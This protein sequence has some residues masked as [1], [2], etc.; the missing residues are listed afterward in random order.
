MTGDER[1]LRAQLAG[2]G[3]ALVALSGGVDSALVLAVAAAEL[4]PDRVT[5][6]TGLS[7]S[8]AATELATARAV[9]DFVGVTHLTPETNELA[10]AD[11]RAND[12]L[13]CYAC[14]AELVDVLTAVGSALPGAVVLTG[15]NR[16]DLADPFRPGIRA[17]AERGARTPLADAGLGKDAVRELARH[18]NLPVADKPATPCLAS[19]VAVGVSVS[20]SR[21]QRIEAAETL[22][23]ER[24]AATGIRPVQLRVRDRGEAASV[25]IDANLVAVAAALPNLLAEIPG[26]PVITLDARGFRSG[27]LNEG[28]AP[29]LPGAVG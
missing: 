9:A 11:Y 18:Y 15:T 14:K 2:I 13:R 22:L 29:A 25:E 17:A 4:G 1:A 10:R 27:S 3:H 12:G 20:R 5:A 24:L 28:L 16:D 7:P 26:F 6:A 21:L 19:R 23:R 8:L